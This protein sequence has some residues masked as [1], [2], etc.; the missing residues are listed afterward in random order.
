MPRIF[1]TA[2]LPVH[3]PFGLDH[4]CEQVDLKVEI[5]LQPSQQRRFEPRIA[6]VCLRHLNPTLVWLAAR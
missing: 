4:D 6:L 3:K 2:V 5:I 1:W